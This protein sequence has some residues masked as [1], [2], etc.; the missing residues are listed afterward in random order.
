MG[1]SMIGTVEEI[2]EMIALLPTCCNATCMILTPI[3]GPIVDEAR[4]KG[5]SFTGEVP[6]GKIGFPFAE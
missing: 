3:T 6:R 1:S 5:G 2:A 4:I